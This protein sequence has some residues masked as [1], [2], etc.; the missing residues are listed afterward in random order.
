MSSAVRERCEAFVSARGTSGG[1]L[2]E[3]TI[4]LFLGVL[5]GIV[6]STVQSSFFEWTLH[7]FWLHRPRPPAAAF[8]AHTLIHHQLCKYE[9]TFEMVEEEQREA[10]TFTWWSGPLLIA[11]SVAPWIVLAWGL[12][13]LGLT[14]PYLGF[15]IA[16][17]ATV[18][19]YYLGYEGFHYLM[20]KPMFPVVE[21][22]RFFQFIKKHHRIHHARMDRNLNVL[23][24]LA[25]Y[26]T[27]TLVIEAVVPSTTS[28]S[29][30]QR[31]RRHSNF[32]KRL[33]GEKE[34]SK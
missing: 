23:L 13:A 2:Y 15:L 1:F 17:A 14:L 18:T 10:M 33:R 6:I 11:I 32:G 20:H 9:D 29:A 22:T 7:R 26:L 28:D 3:V 24:P 19:L 4:I 31:A 34:S 25:D 27:G 12:S 16:F 21:R 5:G 30:R 8:T